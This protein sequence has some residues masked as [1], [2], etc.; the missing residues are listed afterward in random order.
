[1]ETASTSPFKPRHKDKAEDRYR[2]GAT[3]AFI[4]VIIGIGVPMWWHTTTVYRVDLPSSGI[5]SLSE[6]PIKTAVQVTIF[7]QQPSRGQ[8][9]ISELES[10]FSDSDI[11]SVE[12]KQLSPTAKTVQEAH[13]PAALEKLLLREH[14]QS[15][16][17]FMFIEWPNLQEEL[18]LTTERSALMRSDTSSNKIAQ[19]LHAK[20]LQTYRINQ[21]LST[22]DRMGIKSEAPQPTY[23]VIVSVLNPKPRL[24]HA[25]WNIAM[26]V[27]TYIEPWLAQVSGVSNYTVRTQW[28]YR[29]AIEA[30][31]KQVR[32]QSR[33]GRHYA[34]QESA[35]P[36]LLTS[37]AQNLSASTTD[38]P[39]INLVVYIPPCHTAPLH[40]YNSKDQLLTRNGVDA[41]ISS[42]W[43]GF[44]IANPPERVCLAAIND[45]PPVPYHV[46]TTDN[47][48]VMLDQL[49]KLLDISSELHIDGVKVVDIEQLEPRRWEYE[50]Y[51]RRSAIRHISTASSTLQSLIKLLD[52]I[53][54]IVID[55]DVGAAITN[56]YA[57]ILAA[58]AALLEHRLGDASSLAKRA[59]VASERG[60]FDASLLAQLYFPDEQK[61]A[62]YIPL[63]LPIMVPVLSSFNMLRGVL[64]ARRKQKTA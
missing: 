7:T 36:H 47:M 37:I 45:E 2:I 59:F 51:L 5:L 33:L 39:A 54:Y 48:Q 32:D 15:M 14:P 19:L 41:F 49:H 8:L 50:A 1:M 21:I 40:I 12:F 56:S 24:T 63:F 17:D 28:K 18:L 30:E 64:Q 52:Q 55:D 35:L 25:Q 10:A 29:V 13:T 4:V 62:I 6:S 61:Y 58:K 16:G 46:S 23:E 11:W 31:V 34:L 22:D 57:D 42:P 53:S 38:K 26:A 3:V 20:I 9:L 43:G 44:I 27:K 60:F